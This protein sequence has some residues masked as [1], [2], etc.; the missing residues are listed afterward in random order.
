[1][2]NKSAVVLTTHSSIEVE[3]I[4]HMIPI[5]INGQYACFGLEIKYGS[6][7]RITV[8]F[9][10]TDYNISRMYLIIGK[11]SIEIVFPIPS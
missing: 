2:L 3:N 6:G 11:G 5:K 9:K 7:Y 4:C 8:D 10:E 1:M